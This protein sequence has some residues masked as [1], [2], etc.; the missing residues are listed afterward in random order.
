MRLPGE[1]YSDRD[2]RKLRGERKKAERKK[3]VKK[4]VKKVKTNVKKGTEKVKTAGQ[5]IKSGALK[6]AKSPVGKLGLPLAA[7]TTAYFVADQFRK[8][9]RS[10]TRGERAGKKGPQFKSP[11]PETST[12]KTSIVKKTKGPKVSDIMGGAKGPKGPLGGAIDKVKSQPKAKKKE[13]DLRKTNLAGVRMGQRKDGGLTKINPEKQPGLAALK[14]ERPDVVAK[15][16]Y[17]RKGTMVQARG[18]KIGRKKKTKIL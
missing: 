11:K 16:G 17:A 3:K 13:I 5:K 2:R 4:I 12:P 14:K 15:M 18:C 7:L 8:D 1:S 10:Q 6:G 9:K